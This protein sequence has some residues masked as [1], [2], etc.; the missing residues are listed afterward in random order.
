MSKPFVP[1]QVLPIDGDHLKEF[2]GSSTEAVAEKFLQSM[3][4]FPTGSYIHDNGCGSGAVTEAIF[5]LQH[6]NDM[7]FRI[8]ATDRAAAAFAPLKTKVA[9]NGWPVEVR[10]MNCT[11]LDFPDNTF[12]H[13][14]TNFVI[15]QAW[16]DDAKCTSE[17]YRTLRLGGQA[18][19]TTW[20]NLPTMAVFTQTH[21]RLRGQN[22]QRPEMLQ[23]DWYG[24]NDV[25][26]AMLRAGFEEDKIRVEH[27]STQVRVKDP[28]RW[29][30]I[31][32]SIC[33]A[34]RGGWTMAEEEQWN[35]AINL[36]MDAL[37]SGPWYEADG[38]GK[39]GW[40]RL[41]ASATSAT[42]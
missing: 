19:V 11:S 2:L 31:G 5:A 9:H 36:A 12:S 28:R 7:S 10:E 6:L 37:V 4:P 41:I 33:G 26:K 25:K 18:L 34:P 21:E 35:D 1:K 23:Q 30:E 38:E 40:L 24:G 15:L 32:W 29:C 8:E 27:H 16:K 42:K 22:A 14:F 13:S 39:G 3:I 20:E 17:I